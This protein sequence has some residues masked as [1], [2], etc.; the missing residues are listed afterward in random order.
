MTYIEDL[1]EALWE[2]GW[3]VIHFKQ[4]GITQSTA[5]EYI[6]KAATEAGIENVATH[7]LGGCDVL[8]HTRPGQ[9]RCEPD[10]C[11]VVNAY[12]ERKLL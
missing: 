10:D 5:R 9:L 12:K 4:R 6:S 1:A 7:A 11:Y 8:G 2:Q 3:V